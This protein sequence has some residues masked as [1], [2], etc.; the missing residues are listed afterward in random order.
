MIKSL[1]I[2]FVV[3]ISFFTLGTELI[4]FS[5]LKI[6]DSTDTANSVKVVHDSEGKNNLLE[7]NIENTDSKVLSK[8]TGA[9]NVSRINVQ[10]D[11]AKSEIKVFQQGQNNKAVIN[12]NGHKNKPESKKK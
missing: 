12:V 3:L 9:D 11:S 2:L 5:D 6:A 1:S 8:Q 10:G 4:A 7:L